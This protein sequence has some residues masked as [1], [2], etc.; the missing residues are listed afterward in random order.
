MVRIIQPEEPGDTIGVPRGEQ[1]RRDT[2]EV[3][4]DRHTD[5]EHE[6]G[7]VG[8]N[9]QEHPHPPSRGPSAGAGA[10]KSGTS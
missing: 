3:V 10:A 6:R 5:G 9:D 7:A 4:E 2:N 1:A 8:Q